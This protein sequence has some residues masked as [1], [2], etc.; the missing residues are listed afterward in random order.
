MRPFP[1]TGF[2]HGKGGKMSAGRLGL[3][4]NQCRIDA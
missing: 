4:D 1:N 3:K 2:A